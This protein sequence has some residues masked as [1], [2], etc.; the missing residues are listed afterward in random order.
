VTTRTYSESALGIRLCGTTND[1]W[2]P[3]SSTFLFVRQARISPAD[4]LQLLARRAEPKGL[5]LGLSLVQQMIDV[6]NGRLEV[7]SS[8]GSGSTFRVFF[9]ASLAAATSPAK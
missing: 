9:P 4:W 6:H 8:E 3:Q 5:G 7:E 2:H 1:A